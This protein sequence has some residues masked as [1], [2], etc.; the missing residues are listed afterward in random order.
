MFYKSTYLFC[1][2]MLLLGSSA[3]FAQLDEPGIFAIIGFND[4]CL[5]YQQFD[6]ETIEISRL[7]EIAN[8]LS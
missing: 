7:G 3:V 2:T 8:V 1:L 4:Q 5:I 6:G